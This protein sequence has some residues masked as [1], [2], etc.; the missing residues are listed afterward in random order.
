MFIEKIITVFVENIIVI[1]AAIIC[2]GI[3]TYL[4]IN[5]RKFVSTATKT[6]GTI[7]RLDPCEGS[8]GGTIYLPIFEF[9]TLDGQVIT[10]AHDSAQKPAQYQ[11][12]QSI[13][14]LY[15]PENPQG[16]KIGNSTNL[17]MLPVILAVGGVVASISFCRILTGELFKLLFP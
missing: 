13:D 1:L 17:Y 16:A 15:N 9:R 4:F 10:V 2:L 6:K 3:S 8:K 5:T 14:V 7:V 12:G 11:V